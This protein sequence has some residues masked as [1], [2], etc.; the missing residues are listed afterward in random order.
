MALARSIRICPK[1]RVRSSRITKI[2]G[3]GE[4]GRITRKDVERYLS[5]KREPRDPICSK[6]EIEFLCHLYVGLS[7][8]LYDSLQKRCRMLLW[9]LM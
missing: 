1:R 9:L 7:L 4:G 2:S 8:L 3:T 6:E 5:D